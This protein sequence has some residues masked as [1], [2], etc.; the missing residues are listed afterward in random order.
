MRFAAM[1]ELRVEHPHPC[2]CS[3]LKQ[4]GKTLQQWALRALS[5]LQSQ[6]NDTS[7]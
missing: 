5:L 1:D 4:T 7:H 6:I 3:F 2:G